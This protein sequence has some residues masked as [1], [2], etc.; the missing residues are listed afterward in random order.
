[1]FASATAIPI[2]IFLVIYGIII[3]ERINRTAIS[4]FGAIVMIVIG[5]INQEQAIEH[6]DFNTIGLLV[7]MMIIVNIL[8]R[9]GVFEYLAIRAAKKA[10]GDPWKIL[11]L[12]AIITALSS[13]FLDNVTTILLIVPV[14]LVITDTLDTN[15]IPFMFTEIL[16]ANIGGTATLIGDPP[17]IMIGSATGLG[18]VDFLVNLAPVVI[19][20]SFV[21]LFLLKLIYKDFLKAKDE[22]KQKIMKMDETITIK[23]T[24]LL[25]KSL[26]VLF[27]T[28]LGFMVHAQFHL[29]SATVALG[30]AALLL[31]I[32]KIDPEEI[33][34]EVE[35]TTIFFFMGLFILVGSLVEVGVIDNLAKKM[36]EL[37]KG[38]LFIT[39][40]TI[41]WISAIASAF[42]DN[43]PF[44]ATMIP[45]IKSMTASG[46]LDANPL[47]WALALGAC[48]GGNGTIIGASA[49]VIVTGI[50]AKEGRPVSFMSFMRIGFPMM[51]VSIIISTIYLILFYV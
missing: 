13:A 22:N 12:F 7:G 32:S 33:L 3:S 45:L 1:M 30:G 20:I 16:I 38:N 36:L 37:T 14:T 34:F 21:V 48:L 5:I 4:L 19:V 49:N 51:I 29:E 44:V 27:I 46:Q 31:V 41:L 2:T 25:K 35:W 42:L 23:D 24:L 18:F 11:V 47:W 43:I 26:I 6:I 50:M 15:P 40:I 8:K 39:T 28:I 10:K 17:N 9:T